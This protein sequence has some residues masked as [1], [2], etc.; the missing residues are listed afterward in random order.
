MVWLALYSK[1]FLMEDSFFKAAHQHL[2]IDFDGIACLL[3][4]VGLLHFCRRLHRLRVASVEHRQIATT[5]WTSVNQ[6]Y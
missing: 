6:Y 4:N 2:K 5:P 1:T 3:E